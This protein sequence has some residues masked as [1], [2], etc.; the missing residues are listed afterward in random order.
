MLLN[1][2][3]AGCIGGD[4]NCIIDNKD[5]THHP[6]SKISPSLTRMVRTFN[7]KDSYRTLH[8]HELVYSHYY[9]TQ[10]L[11]EGGTRIDRSYSWGDVQVVDAF[12]EPIAFSDHM[13]YVVK[14]SLPANSAR[15]LSPR[16]RPLFKVRPE[17]IHDKLFQENLR[18]SMADWKEVK[19]LGLDIL[20]WWELIVKPGIKKLAIHRSKELN[21]E[22]HGQLN[23]LLLRQAYLAN[24]LMQGDFSQYTELRCVQVDIE[25]WYQQES[26]KVILQSRSD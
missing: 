24:K 2:L 15:I 13:G 6:A 7:M 22:K 25:A 16:S 10:Q 14:L 18:D 21:R 3:D 26:E 9:H 5:C 23:L 20:V 19:E 17:V 11:G 1:R 12:Y 4:L 8:P